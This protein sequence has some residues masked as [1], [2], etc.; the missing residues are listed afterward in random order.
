MSV[1]EI[2]IDNEYESLG[3]K[4]RIVLDK[5]EV[6]NDSLFFGKH[7]LIID[8]ESCPYCKKLKEEV[9]ST[10][11]GSIPI[12]YRKAGQLEGLS[13]Q[14]PLWATPTII[15]LNNGKEALGHQGF[16]N[17]KEFYK[18]LG[19]FKLGDSEAFSVAFNEG[20]DSRYCKEYEIFK[21]TPDGQFVDKLSGEPL[22]DTDDRFNSRTGWL[23]F[24]KPLS[25]A[26]YELP[27][28]SYGMIRTE[29]RS[30]SSDIHLG[31]V[32]DDGPNGLPRY[33]I[34][35]TVLEFKPRKLPNS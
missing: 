35:A 27:D 7:I 22:F 34:N 1:K 12:S 3:V 5:K 33:C 17:K 10:Y 25:G 19:Y 21:N 24:I 18:A 13:I 8:S 2:F 4:D 29:V 26:V 23:S 20:T 9:I 15:F 6:D 16:L 31:H 11:K 32:F 14:T 28:H 30:T